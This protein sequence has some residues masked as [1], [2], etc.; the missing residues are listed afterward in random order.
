MPESKYPQ[1]LRVPNCARE[2]SA[3]YRN[4]SEDLGGELLVARQGRLAGS[5]DSQTESQA[6][7]S[8]ALRMTLV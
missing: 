6:H 2:F 8:A 7:R 1:F 3:L 4:S 5:F